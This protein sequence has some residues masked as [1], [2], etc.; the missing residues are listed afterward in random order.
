[1]SQNQSSEPAMDDPST[2]NQGFRLS[3]AEDDEVDLSNILLSI[4]E[5]NLGIQGQAVGVT[6]TQYYNRKNLITFPLSL[7]LNRAQEEPPYPR[8]IQ[9]AVTWRR[10]MSCMAPQQR[11]DYYLFNREE[12]RD[13][14]YSNVTWKI[15]NLCVQV[16]A[17]ANAKLTNLIGGT[18]NHMKAE[19][20]LQLRII[21][22][23]NLCIL[24]LLL[25]L[26]YLEHAWERTY[27]HFMSQEHGPQ[28]TNQFR[29]HCVLAVHVQVCSLLV[30]LVR[31][32][33]S[34]Q[35]VNLSNQ[36]LETDPIFDSDVLR[37]YVWD[38]TMIYDEHCRGQEVHLS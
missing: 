16:V 21:G 25:L 20:L 5:I 19:D 8:C 23:K 7:N 2:E 24:G 31:M 22:H 28:I 26:R 29:S 12:A 34:K 38:L 13:E 37:M 35:D 27:Q 6:V 11:P 17:S 32:V 9:R 14:G 18:L 15:G 36:Y 10:I 1:M 30:S 3:W 33:R 4:E